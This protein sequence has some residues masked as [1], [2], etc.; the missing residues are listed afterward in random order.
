MKIHNME[1]GTPEWFEVRKG[2]LT[3]SHGTAIAT[4]G[5]GLE[6]YVKEIVLN[7]FTTKKQLVGADFDRGNELEPIARMKYEFEK[8][9][10]VVEVGFIEISNRAGYSPD[11]LVGDE[12][13][14]EIKARNDAKHLDLLLTNKIDSGT[15]WQMQMGMLATNRK[16]CDFISYNPNFKKNSM[17]VKR[18]HRDEVAIQKLRKGIYEGSKMIEDLLRQPF[19]QEEI[20]LANNLEV[21]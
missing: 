6:T 18:V 20:K 15:V 19:I 10:E 1:Q 9:V 16:W 21:K 3:A 13:L 17:Y 5:A 7:Y 12:G 11:G 2:K 4:A 8:N 14:I